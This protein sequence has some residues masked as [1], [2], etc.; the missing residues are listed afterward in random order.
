MKCL[1]AECEREGN[2]KQL[3]DPHYMHWLRQKEILPFGTLMD[4]IVLVKH[5]KR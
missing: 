1:V 5:T 4:I 2:R 3:C